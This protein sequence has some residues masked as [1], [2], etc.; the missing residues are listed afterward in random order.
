MAEQPDKQQGQEQNASQAEAGE[1]KSPSGTIVYASILAE[2]EEELERS[3]S[4]LFWSGLA[5]GLSMGFSLLGVALLQAYLPEAPWQK[6]VS[7][8]GYSLGFLVVILG[9]QQLFTENTLTPVLQ[10]LRKKDGK[11]LLNVLRLWV[12]VLVANMIGAVVVAFALARM[13]SLAP[14]VKGA[15]MRVSEDCLGHPFGTLVLRGIFAG[16]LIALIV[17]LLP[18]AEAARIWVIIILTYV[19]ALGDFP[20]IIAGAVEAFA[21]AWEGT[22][23]WGSVLGTY[24]VPTLLG[25]IIGGV[26]LVA[27]LNHAQVEGGGAAVKPESGKDTGL[28]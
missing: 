6:L 28:P 13:P 10:L 18:F 12:V 17:W 2:A 14:G 15:M 25:N 9:R 5:A 20:H 8:L 1:R 21:L 7:R 23:S 27:A 19:V 24:I 3:S 4:A 16:W 26:M 22:A 11:T